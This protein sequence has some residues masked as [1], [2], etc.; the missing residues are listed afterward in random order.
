MAVIKRHTDVVKLLLE[1][2]ADVNL[3]LALTDD[4]LI[5]LQAEEIQI[6]GSGA[7]IEAC[8]HGDSSLVDLLLDHGAVD[9][10]NKALAVCVKNHNDAL[11]CKLLVRHTFA[12]PEFRVNKKCLDVESIQYLSKG[13]S[14]AP[15]ALCPGCPVSPLWTG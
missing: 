4:D 14:V 7:L 12:D 10:D 1:A 9:Q 13:R 11:A 6:S 2:G 8:N 3:P 15:S 5:R